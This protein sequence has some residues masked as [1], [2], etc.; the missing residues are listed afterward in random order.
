MPKDQYRLL[1]L[2][3]YPSRKTK[4]VSVVLPWHI[5]MQTLTY[6]HKF[7]LSQFNNNPRITQFK[8]QLPWSIA[9]ERLH[10]VQTSLPALGPQIT[11]ET[12]DTPNN[13]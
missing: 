13:Q 12:T 9:P 2:T 1:P 10:K 5:T 4:K 7:Q 11:K 6:M 3:M 8:F